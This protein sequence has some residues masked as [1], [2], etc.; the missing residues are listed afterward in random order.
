MPPVPFPRTEPACELDSAHS[1]G[2]KSS[3]R[4]NPPRENELES[5]SHAYICAGRQNIEKDHV[6]PVQAEGD[7]DKLKSTSCKHMHKHKE[8]AQNELARTFAYAQKESELNVNHRIK[9]ILR[10]R[11]PKSRTGNPAGTN[12]L[13]TSSET[14][15]GAKR[16][17][18]DVRKEQDE[19][20]LSSG[21]ADHHASVVYSTISPPSSKHA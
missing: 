9:H 12:K 3:S 6:H 4:L 16:Q 11:K 14:Q 15:S 7:I 13:I 10:P 18:N 20:R 21:D 17:M 5:S 1:Q 19:L 8:Q 2:E